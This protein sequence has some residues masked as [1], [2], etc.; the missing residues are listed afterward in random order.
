MYSIVNFSSGLLRLSHFPKNTGN[1]SRKPFTFL[2][3]HQFGFI[4]LILCAVLLFGNIHPVSAAYYDSGQDGTNWENAYIISSAEDLAALRDRVNSGEEPSG[5][6]YVLGSDIDLTAYT[7]WEGIGD[8]P[9]FKGHFDGQNHTIQMNSQTN[10]VFAGLFHTVDSGNENIAVRNLNLTGTIKADCAGTV[11]HYLYSGIVE[12]CSF[13][14][15]I[16]T[17]GRSYYGAGGIAAHLEG[18]TVRNC[19]VS[20]NISGNEY[21]GGIAGEVLAGNI[22]NCTVDDSTR[23][24]AEQIGG[25]VGYVNGSF[26]GR[27]SGNRWPSIYP[28]TGNDYTPQPQEDTSAEWNGHRYQIFSDTL[29][30]EEAK[31]HCESLGGHLATITSQAEQNAVTSLLTNSQGSHWLGAYADDSGLW[32]WVTDEPFEKQY[33]NYAEG[34][35]DGSG[36]Y[37]LIL[38]SGFWDDVRSDENTAGFICEWDNEPQRVQAAPSAPAFLRWLAE[39]RDQQ[40]D[41]DGYLNGTIPSP[42]DT[43]HLNN[44]LPRISAS[45]VFSTSAFASSFDGRKEFGLPEARDQGKGTNTCWAFASIA[46]MEASYLAQHFTSLNVTPDFSEL[47]VVWEVKSRDLSEAVLLQMGT[48]DEARNVLLLSPSAPVSESIFPYSSDASNESISADWHSKSFTKLPVTLTS[49]APRGNI[50]EANRDI[51]KQDII[52]NGGVFCKIRYDKSAYSETNHSY[53]IKDDRVPNH[54]VFI[55]GWDDNYSADLFVNTPPVKGAWLVRNSYGSGYGD[56]G[57]FWLSYAQGTDTDRNI[58]DATAFIVSED[59]IS[60]SGKEKHEHDENGKTKVINSAW[61]SNVFRSGRDENLVQISFPTTDNNTEYKVFVN[62]FG[63]NAPSYPGETDTPLMSGNFPSAGDHTLTL[64]SPIQLYSG[65]Y[66][67]VIVKITHTS[68]YDSPTAVEGRIDGYISPDVGERQ[69]FFAAG[70]P[71]PSVWQ[72]GKYIDGGPYNACIKTVTIPRISPI[73]E[74]APQITTLSLPDASASNEY[75]Y[76]LT[77]SGTGTIEWRGGN[78]PDGMALSRQGVLSGVPAKSG[79][80]KLNITAFNSVDSDT[81]KLKLKV[82]GSSEEPDPDPDPEPEPE[83]TPTPKSSI[84]SSGSGC[85]AGMRA[86]FMIL[87]VAGLCIKRNR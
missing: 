62:T 63:K 8:E 58:I 25:I 18:G 66:Y 37:L 24:T 43:S 75:M 6:Y 26:S 84:G 42:I 79:E 5:K 44:N 33:Q 2:S 59:K 40:Q 11:V 64:P 12:N 41:N 19:R 71:V 70:E 7:D 68:E 46:A 61:S 85:N 52:S 83:P 35:P 45:S 28:E 81:A 57:Y 73:P 56:N 53:Y 47:Q 87:A 34:Q 48:Q 16:T 32:H 36:G 80:Y 10:S 72:D 86:V 65:D 20:A 51:I 29:S 82:T 21:A 27:I 9:Y 55:A 17:S 1:I 15:T 38:E 78:I 13:S 4:S 22:K 67:A 31:T 23:I 50:T 54:A 39:S 3:V 74:T 60:Q 30:W 76:T 77:A 14:G 69:S 49:T